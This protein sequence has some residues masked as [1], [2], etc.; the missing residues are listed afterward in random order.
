MK[1]G[2]FEPEWELMLARALFDAGRYREA[3]EILPEARKRAE[4]Q[5]A[6]RPEHDR[7]VAV[8]AKAVEL[9]EAVF[10]ETG[11]TDADRFHTRDEK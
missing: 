11:T 9:Q 5:L 3:N 1:G 10:E 8:V 4:A 6:Q 2:T 7:L